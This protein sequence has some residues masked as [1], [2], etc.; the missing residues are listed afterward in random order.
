[1]GNECICLVGFE[2]VFCLYLL[3]L[4]LVQKLYP[5]VYDISPGDCRRYRDIPLVIVG[6]G[7]GVIIGLPISC[8]V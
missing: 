7:G 8:L 6:E 2:V 1:M 3:A 5:I 4:T